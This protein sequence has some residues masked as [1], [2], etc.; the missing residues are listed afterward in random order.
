[1]F[2]GAARPSLVD[3]LFAT[4]PPLKERLRRIYGRDVTLLDATPIIEE[5]ASNAATLPDLPYT[6]AGFAGGDTA[7]DYIQAAY[8][9]EATSATPASA[10]SAIAFGRNAV[11]QIRLAPEL[12]TAIREPESA[13]AVVYALLLGQGTDRD[14]QIA[15][16]KAEVPKQASFVFYLNEAI[17]KLPK[18]M[19]LP[20]LDLAMPALRELSDFERTR[21]LETVDKLIAADNKISLSEFV[22]QTILTRRL[23]AHSGRAI[24]VK[25]NSIAALK[26]ECALLLSLL[27]Y[28]S[29]SA[30]H[31]D[32][33]TAFRRGIA[34]CAELGLTQENLSAIAAI[35]FAGIRNALD[36]LNQLA[37]LEKPTLI[38]ALL[39]TAEPG[40]AL[41]ITIADILR[42]I[43]AAL[44]VPLPPD[45][46]AVYA[47]EQ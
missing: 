1:L 23:D 10:P 28:V 21:V 15:L 3:G 40:R 20:L 4:H 26:D 32:A 46:A 45:V 31:E 18:N 47:A 27:A 39:A 42:A 22:L 36:R 13:C 2:L 37:P 38:K 30:T 5:P 43:C 8:A 7:N 44:E 29:T 25:F 24:P 19:R 11:Q 17:D 9:A 34:L 16:L 41:P 33:A 6:A 35:N 12:D 14:A